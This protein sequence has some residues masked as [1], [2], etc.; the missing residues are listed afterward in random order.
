MPGSRCLPGPPAAGPPAGTVTLESGRAQRGV[1]A[2]VWRPRCGD[3]ATSES[4][5]A[6]RDGVIKV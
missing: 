4:G 3:Q 5:M 1:A 2:E 6:G